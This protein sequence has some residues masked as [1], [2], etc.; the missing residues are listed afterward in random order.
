MRFLVDER[1]KYEKLKK[2]NFSFNDIGN[3][4]YNNYLSQFLFACPQLVNLFLIGCNISYQ[5]FGELLQV[6]KGL[7]PF[8]ASFNFLRCLEILAKKYQQI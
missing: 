2:L 3:F 8:F 7:K 4:L 1:V 5:A 6:F